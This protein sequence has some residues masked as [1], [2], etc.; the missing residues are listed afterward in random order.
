MY[1][2]KVFVCIVAQQQVLDDESITYIIHYLKPNKITITMNRWC[3][4]YD[5]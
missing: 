2:H 5:T 3:C 1:L 4:R